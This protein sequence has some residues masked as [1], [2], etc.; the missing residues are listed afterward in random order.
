MYY[1]DYIE[2]VHVKS[3][4][5]DQVDEWVKTL[6]DL[7]SLT[8]KRNMKD[9]RYQL[10]A[11]IKAQV[12]Y[13]CQSLLVPPT[14]WVNAKGER[15]INVI[16]TLC[17]VGKIKFKVAVPS[18]RT[19]EEIQAKAR[20]DLGCLIGDLSQYVYE[21]SY[22]DFDVFV[23]WKSKELNS[24][25]GS[26]P[27]YVKDHLRGP[28]E[29]RLFVEYLPGQSYD[30]EALLDRL[31]ELAQGWPTDWLSTYQTL[32]EL[33]TQHPYQYKEAK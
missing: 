24:Y 23:G 18:L 11:E 28:S 4:F 30:W 21:C 16:I 5:N 27:D 9:S 7:L 20:Y 12:A 15:S 6:S 8:A 22:N 17:D 14:I 25:W 32:E 1:P 2:H 31:Y 13:Q 29:T 3:R 19:P 26:M 33:S 10:M